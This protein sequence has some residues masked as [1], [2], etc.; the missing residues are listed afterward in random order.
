MYGYV[1]REEQEANLV[2]ESKAI[3]IIAE[4]VVRVVMGQ[5]M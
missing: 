4:T 2:P 5:R 3:N 1:R